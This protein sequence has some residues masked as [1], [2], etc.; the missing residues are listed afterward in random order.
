MQAS[1]FEFNGDYIAGEFVQAPSPDLEITTRSPADQEDVVGRHRCQV[2]HVDQAVQAAAEAQGAWKRLAAQDRAN[3]LRRY[4]E[5]A[6]RRRAEIANTIAREVGKALWDANGE[7]GAIAAKVDLVLGDGAKWTEDRSLDAVPAELR[8]MPHGVMAVV[9]PFN[10][11]GHL[12][13]GQILPALALGNTVVFKPSDKTPNTAVLLAQC[14]DEA[15]FPPGVVNVV[16]GGVAAAEALVRHADVD[17]IL[18]TG[19]APV[20]RKILEANLDSPGKVV[21][22]ELGGKNACIVLDDANLEWAARHIAFAAFASA[23]QRCTATSR[24]FATPGVARPLAVRVAEIAKAL[25]V[26]HPLDEGV[27]MGPVIDAGSR[28]RLLKAQSAASAAGFE[29]LAG[30]SEGERFEVA[31]REGFYVRPA[32]RWAPDAEIKVPGYTHDELFGPDVAVY[33]VRDAA[34]AVDLLNATR[35]GL[36]GAVFTQSRDTFESLAMDLRVGVLNWN[37][38]SAGASGKLPFGGVKDSGNHRPAGIT[39]GL[40]CA[41]PQARLLCPPELQSD[42]PTWPGFPA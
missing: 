18:F 41:F 13:N 36:S 28:D 16:Q 2:S 31:G 10:F 14:F 4:Q 11:P 17:G 35:Y 33:S 8:F 39:M 15:G 22:L 32:V 19:S 1:T 30:T 3:L 29:L 5:I 6:K 42:L 26:G 12:P 37:K 21:A 7:A 34:Q 23:G 27:F 25:S 38:G 24:V 40:S 9:G 20:G